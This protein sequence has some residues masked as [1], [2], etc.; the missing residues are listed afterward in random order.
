MKNAILI[1]DKDSVV[2]IVDGAGKG[3]TVSFFRGETKETLTA[4]DEIPPCHKMAIRDIPKGERVIKYGEI[5]GEAMEDIPVGG[6]VSH[7]NIQSLPRNYEE[8]LSREV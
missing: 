2:T 1:D 6:W 3:E 7:L 8:E 5:I 4:A